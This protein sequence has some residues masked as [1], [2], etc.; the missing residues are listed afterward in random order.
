MAL[1]GNLIDLPLIDL[2]QVLTLQ[3]KTGILSLNR[4]FSQA[5]VAFTKSRI[6]SAYVHH[7]NG[8]E[9]PIYKQGEDALYDLL[10]WP[11]G[12]F[13]FE[14]TSTLPPV[15]N[16]K[17]QLDYLILE[18]CRRKDEKEQMQ[19]LNGLI[20]ARPR[21]VP[22][23]PVQAEITLDLEEWR[24]LYM[25]NGQ[26]SI[27]EIADNIRQEPLSILAIAEKLEKKGLIVLDLHAGP[28]GSAAYS[29]AENARNKTTKPLQPDFQGTGFGQPANRTATAGEMFNRFPG[30]P[31]ALAA[32]PPARVIQTPPHL[33]AHGNLVPVGGPAPH[34]APKGQRGL[35]AGIMAKIRS[36]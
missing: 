8:S 21:L 30:T 17:H 12:Q 33:A 27:K 31:P 29:N 3:N 1:Q 28:V 19:R 18:H 24:I 25:I 14:L 7:A 22:N 16:V 15:E 26:L 10:G 5:Q 36:L 20:T 35:L 4:D 23:P 13:T 32:V 9:K 34:A 2:V 11:D 6:Y